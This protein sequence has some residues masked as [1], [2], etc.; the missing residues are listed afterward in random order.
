MRS[1]ASGP[2]RWTSARGAGARAAAAS[3]SRS[4]ARL[5]R[6]APARP[7]PKRAASPFVDTRPPLRTGSPPTPERFK[8]AA[9]RS[10][11][12][13]GAVRCRPRP[14]QPS[15]PRRPTCAFR[16]P[17]LAVAHSC[18][19]TWW[20]AV[21]DDALPDDLRW[22]AALHEAGLAGRR[23]TWSRRARLRRRDAAGL[24]L[25]HGAG[26]RAQRPRHSSGC[27]RGAA[28]AARFTA[29]RLWDEGKNLAVLDRA[30]ARLPVSV[31]AAG[32]LRGPNGAAH[33]AAS[34]PW[35]SVRSTARRCGPL[36]RT[37]D[38]RLARALRALR[39]RGAGSRAGRLRAGPLRH[40]DLPRALGRCRAVR[41]PATTAAMPRPRSRACSRRGSCARGWAQARADAAGRLHGRGDGDRRRSRL[42]AR[43]RGRAAGGRAHE[44]RLF[45]PLAALL[46]EPRQRA[47]PARRA[48][49]V[50][51]PRP[52]RRGLRARGRLEPRATCCDDARRGRTRRLPRSLSRTC[53]RS[54]YGP[55]FDAAE[56]LRRRRPRHRARMERARARGARSA[57]RGAAAARFTLLFHDTHHRAVSDPEAIR[58]FDLDGY[59]GVLAFGET[60]AAVY[61]Q[62]GLGRPR[63]RLARG[64]RHPRVP[65]A[66]RRGRARRASSGSATGATASA[67]PN[68]SSFL[69][70]PAQRRAC[71]STSTACAI[72]TT[73]CDTLR[74][75]RRA[76]SRLAAECRR[77]GRVRAPSRDRPRAAPLLRRAAARHPDHPGVRGAGLRHPAG[78][79]AVERQ[80]G[81]VHAGP[82]FPDGARRRRDDSAI[83]RRCAH[84]PDLRAALAAHGLATIR[85]RHTCA[86]RVDE[87][88]AVLDDAPGLPCP[89]GHAHEHRL[90]RLEPAVVLLERR[91][92]LL[93]RHAARPRAARLSH[94]L[95]RA[96]RLRPAEASRHR[97]AGLGRRRGLPRHRRRALRARHRGGG[98]APTS[99]SRRAASACSTTCCSRA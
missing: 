26:R 55:D 79:G 34:H 23:R 91:R 43:Y 25:R 38:L 8:R 19:A 77:A 50:D 89:L 71:R 99:S 3:R 54:A 9:K 46:L 4:S 63:V 24:R 73:R 68:S 42:T 61:R 48:A 62:L 41:R 92:H 52:R 2:M 6:T 60:L 21:R 36:A 13:R 88:L 40:P 83:S 53:A 97:A 64:R 87:L 47:F 45:H 22:R 96:R 78:L 66:G 74:P 82:G 32:P 51:P 57:A 33:R 80:R 49:R 86:H 37:A 93:S 18:V 20:G 35:R 11:L 72:P 44:D 84:D 94:H 81:P 30:A 10:R 65:S 27:D 12:W 31:D 90:L 95:L 16:L 14:S 58:A 39:P 69:F 1:A 7:M 85:A 15:G 75:L 5:R 29:G 67:R 76:L 59:D 70:G 17:V 56:A 28:G 98:A